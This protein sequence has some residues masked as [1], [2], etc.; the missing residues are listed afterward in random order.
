MDPKDLQKLIEDDELGLLTVKPKGASIPTGDERLINSFQEI[1][2]FIKTA[3]REPEPSRTDMHEMKLHN[4]LK[5]FR[6][7][8]AK[9]EQ[10]RPHDEL[11]LLGEPQRIESIEDVFADDDL[12]LL[13][14]GTDIFDLKFVPRET[15]QLP[16]YIAKRKPC[17]DFKS[18]AHLFKQ[19]HAELTGGIRVLTRF[20]NE[21]QINKGDFFVLKGVLVYVADEGTTQ[22]LSHGHINARLRCIFE[23]GTESDMLLRSL[24]SALYKDGRRVTTPT[25]KLAKLVRE[26]G[27]EDL[28]TG[29]IYVLKS[30]SDRAELRSMKHLYKIGFSRT[31]VED[32]IKNASRE[33]TY[34]MAP[35]EVVASFQCYNLNP[36]KFE[37]LLHTFFG[38][39][40]LDVD[41][42]DAEG[43]SHAPREWFVAP[44]GIITKAVEL[45]ITEEILNYRYDAEN[46]QIV[47]RDG[48]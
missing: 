48:G 18:F 15:P 4:R 14:D 36:H 24:A 6:N 16:D 3:G 43:R 47:E 37:N 35:V 27:D 45:L 1:T 30:L 17:K 7:D 34:L 10:L 33:V 22:Q 9:I 20:T 11:K 28:Q 19:C 13:N 12:G 39:A 29:F 42:F 46:Q 8:E 38:Q 31:A 32:R 40:C 26:V 23:N 41:V 44:I 2:D 25:D 21:T 5:S